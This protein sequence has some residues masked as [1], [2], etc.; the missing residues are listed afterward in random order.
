[1]SHFWVRTNHFKYKEMF[2]QNLMLTEGQTRHVSLHI[3]FVNLLTILSDFDATD[4]ALWDLADIRTEELV[5]FSC[6]NLYL[7]VEESSILD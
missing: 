2:E 3:F 1:M 7:G 4:R 5:S 6:V